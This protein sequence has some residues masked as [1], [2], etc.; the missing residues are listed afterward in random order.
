MANEGIWKQMDGRHL[1]PVEQYERRRKLDNKNV[2]QTKTKSK[3]MN[4]KI[5]DECAR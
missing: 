4:C 2:N 1:T 3:T 5:E